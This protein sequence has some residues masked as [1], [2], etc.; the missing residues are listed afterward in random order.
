MVGFEKVKFQGKFRV[1][2]QRVLDNFEDHIKDG[3]INVVAAPG[4]GK[5]V[6]GLELICR[7]GSPCIVLSPTTAIR[8]QWGER[9]RELF[10]ENKEDFENLFSKNLHNIKLLTSIT[11]QAL[12]TAI[13]KV[14]ADD[15][16][17]EDCS[18]VELFEVMKDFGIKTIC[19]DEAHHLKNEWQKALEKFISAL[20]KDVKIIS[21]T[22]TPPYDSE[23]SEWSR[24]MSICGEIDEEIFV[25]ELVA[26]N[27]L[28][29]HQD[30]VYFNYP[31]ENE[32]S[33]FEEH[34]ENA[35]LAVEELGKLELFADV[36]KK[37]NQ[38]TDYEALFLSVKEYVSLF[39]L[40]KHYNYNLKE[41][42]IKELTTKKTLPP[43]KMSYAEC[44]IQFLLD[45]DL[46]KAW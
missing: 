31:V 23:G 30:Y 13:E 41:K 11:Y 27:T 14:H 6:L 46:I 34:K 18:D 24:Y 36:Y 19:L 33:S 44:A 25:P 17:E 5:T 37:L 22:A 7:I 12:Y 38:T 20:D 39:I 43:F 40:L 35:V 21:L 3:K 10:L 32:I 26:Q 1:Y 28:C 4:S 42:L 9:F 2:Q 15:E 8:E 29:P 16:D 45:G